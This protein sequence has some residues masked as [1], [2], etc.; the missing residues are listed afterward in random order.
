MQM[1]VDCF[2]LHCLISMVS[3]VYWSLKVLYTHIPTLMAEAA[4]QGADLLVWS[5]LVQYL[6][7]G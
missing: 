3:T 4:M 2:S 1:Y 5:D 7:R 6:T